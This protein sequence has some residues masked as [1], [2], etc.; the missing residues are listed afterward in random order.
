MFTLINMTSE[1]SYNIRQTLTAELNLISLEKV[2]SYRDTPT[3]DLTPP[4]EEESPLSGD[5]VFHNVRMKYP[6]NN[7]Y[8]LNDL[9][10]T[11][12]EGEKVA[13]MGRTGAGKSSVFMALYRLFEMEPDSLITIGGRDIRTLDLYT[14]R[15]KCLS[16]SVQDPVKLLPLTTDS[17]PSQL[18]YLSI[19][20]GDET[21]VK[22]LDE[23][24]GSISTECEQ[25]C[26]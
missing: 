5:V 14:L 11:I 2:L 13:L 24:F 26:Q 16:S 25:L 20:G 12:K 9:S 17:S 23:P 3:E 19:V 4:I 1:L 22:C 7:N 21:P 10:M 6:G 8:S 18:K 15:K